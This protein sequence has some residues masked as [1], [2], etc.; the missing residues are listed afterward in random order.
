MIEVFNL[1]I[2]SDKQ[3]KLYLR[4]NQSTYNLIENYQNKTLASIGYTVIDVR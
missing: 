1:T 2:Q 4:I 3:V